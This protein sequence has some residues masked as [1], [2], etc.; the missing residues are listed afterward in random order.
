MLML[1]IVTDFVATGG[2]QNYTWNVI[3]SEADDMMFQHAGKS[4]AK[5]FDGVKVDSI[6]F[7]SMGGSGNVSDDEKTSTQE[8]PTLGRPVSASY[9][10]KADGLCGVVNFDYII[11]ATGRLGLLNRKYLK[12]RSY[13]R[14]LKNI[15]IWG[16][17]KGTGQYGVGTRRA[18]S[19]FFEALQGMFSLHL[20]PFSIPNTKLPN[21]Y[22]DE[23][24]WAWFIPLH[25]GTISIGI[26]MNEET[27][28]KKKAGHASTEEFYKE[29][30]QLAPDLIE[31]V[32]TGKLVS[33][34]KSASDYSYHASSYAIPYARIVGDAGCFIDPFFSSGVHMAVTGALSAAIT[35]SATIKGDCSEEI[36]AQWHSN[37]IRGAYARFLFV[38]LGAYKQMQNQKEFVLSDFGENNF[39]RAF[40][41]FGPGTFLR[42]SILFSLYS[43]ISSNV[44]KNSHSRGC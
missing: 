28:K 10:R 29:A 22:L 30:L 14:Q 1:L 7:A 17:W 43:L 27:A 19:P 32:A 16:Y 38:V 5:I 6:A 2:P 44:M 9:T 20:P 8:P 37:K 13:T 11:D 15:A 25:D 4:G 23:S 34:T 39:D 40:N 33:D 21:I 31:L 18:N 35:I 3:R 36:A 41:F 24:G 12:N 42:P 26:A